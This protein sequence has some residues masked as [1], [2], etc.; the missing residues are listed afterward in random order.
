MLACWIYLTAFVITCI[1]L[2]RQGGIPNILEY[3]RGL[4]SQSFQGCITTPVVIQN[5][6]FVLSQAADGRGID[7]CDG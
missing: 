1:N 3:T 7:S 4:Y 2:L 5:R 6:D